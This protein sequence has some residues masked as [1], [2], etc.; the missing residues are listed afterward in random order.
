MQC[1]LVMVGVYGALSSASI[2]ELGCRTCC[3]LK[4]RT[5]AYWSKSYAHPKER[6]IKEC[7]SLSSL[8]LRLL[9]SLITT[10][11][12]Y[13]TND[14]Y[15]WVEGTLTPAIPSPT[16]LRTSEDLA[17]ASSKRVV[18][19][20]L[21]LGDSPVGDGDTSIQGIVLDILCRVASLHR[22]GPRYTLHLRSDS[23]THQAAE[24]IA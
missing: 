4:L 7:H 18:P 6:L 9:C 1:C 3:I 19:L 16:G 5:V 8:G 2:H 21:A 20:L 22:Y 14:L 15:P 10:V 24:L 11:K 12:L 13:G 17:M 23:P